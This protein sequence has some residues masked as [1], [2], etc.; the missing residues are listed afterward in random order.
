VVDRDGS[1][2][3]ASREAEFIG[4]WHKRDSRPGGALGFLRFNLLRRPSD[5]QAT[6]FVKPHVC[7]DASSFWLRRRAAGAG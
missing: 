4:V 7:R 2:I 6:V 1:R 5:G 3:A